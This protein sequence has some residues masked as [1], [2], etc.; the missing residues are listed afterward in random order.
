MDGYTIG[1]LARRTGLTVKTIRFYS[2]RGLVPPSGRTAAGYRLY[3]LRAVARLDLVRTLRDLGVDLATISRVVAEEVSLAEVAA[4]HAEA[5]AV[6]LRTLRLRRAVLTA[7]ARRG[8]DPVEMEIMHR[9]ARL[10]EAERHRLI[11]ELLEPVPEGI[12][13]SLTPELP[14][15][16]TDAQVEAWVEVA[17]LAQDPGFRA[18]VRRMVTHHLDGGLRRGPVAAIRDGMPPEQVMAEYGP[19]DTLVAKLEAVD[20]RWDRYQQLVAVINGWPEPEPVAPAVARFLA[21]TASA[22]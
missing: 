20:P 13:R 2:D 9:L 17:E 22:G 16:P 1:D 8:S 11:A 14:D 15:D 19:R 12:A 4:T 10:S 6:Q 21:A 7:V 5:L 18:A 3:D